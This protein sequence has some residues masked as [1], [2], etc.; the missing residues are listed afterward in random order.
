MSHFSGAVI[1]EERDREIHLLIQE[2]VTTSPFFP[3]KRGKKFPGGR[4]NFRETPIETLTREIREELWVTIDG[5]LIPLATT[6]DVFHQMHFF[7]VN[8]LQ[9]NGEIRKI[10]ISDTGST[11]PP[12]EWVKAQEI[13][14]SPG[15]LDSHQSAL[16]KTLRHFGLVG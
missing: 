12:P 8:S 13:G 6:G 11:L 10:E 3:I 16:V 5:P 15:F 7:L 14:R 4:S 9:L 1:W 2:F